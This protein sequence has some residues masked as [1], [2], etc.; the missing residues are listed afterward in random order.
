MNTDLRHPILA[1]RRGLRAPVTPGV[2][3]ERKTPANVALTVDAIVPERL[4]DQYKAE[5]WES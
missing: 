3:L 1:V 4:V 5:M 2:M